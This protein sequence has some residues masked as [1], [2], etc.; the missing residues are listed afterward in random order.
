MLK[1][2]YIHNFKCFENFEFKLNGMPSSLLIGKNGVGKSS[3][4]K[5]LLIFQNI[6]RGVNRVGEL[7][8]SSDF[9]YGRTKIP[10]RF[11]IEIQLQKRTYLYSLALELPEKFKELRVLEERLEVDGQRVYARDQAQ[12]SL[13]KSH[14]LGSDAMFSVDWHLVALPLIQAQSED[15]PISMLKSWFE[16]MVILAPIPKNMRGDSTEETLRPLTDAANLS[17]WLAGILNRQFSIYTTIFDHLA[18]VMPDLL[19][20][21]NEVVGKEAKRLMFQFKSED[22]QLLLPFDDLSDGE[23]CF[24]LCAVI[25]AANKMYG[26]IFCFWDEPD[27]Y[28]S[29]SEVGYFVMSLRR[30]FGE[31]GQVVMTSHNE[32]A[33]RR[34]SDENTWI[35]DRRNHLTPTQIRLLSDLPPHANLIQALIAG[36]ISL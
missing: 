17:S 5:A 18:E 4:S 34:F 13:S 10:M 15:D 16:K 29:L 7:V 31:Q 6:G 8:A 2:L 26:P 36:D 14:H 23:K 35:M 1:R 25:L 33:I 19:D 30:Q 27:H 32:E 24:F 21:R 11:E 9:A 28:L 12:V 20:F 3:I 22:G